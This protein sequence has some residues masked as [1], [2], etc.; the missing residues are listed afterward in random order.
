M[1][2]NK[3]VLWPCVWAH[4]QGHEWPAVGCGLLALAVLAEPAFQAWQLLSCA[5]SLPVLPA[6]E[7][8]YPTSDASS[9]HTGNHSTCQQWQADVPL[10]GVI[11]GQ[12]YMRQLGRKGSPFKCGAMASTL[13]VDLLALSGGDEKCHNYPSLFFQLQLLWRGVS[14]SAA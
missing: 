3:S 4:L 8:R 1:K 2:N 7:H 14:R 13:K 6:R 11:V 9:V 12:R 10:N 5:F